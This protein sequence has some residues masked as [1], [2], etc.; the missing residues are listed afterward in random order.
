MNLKQ[1]RDKVASVAVAIEIAFMLCF[2]AFALVVV[3]S[4]AL[5]GELAACWFDT[6]MI[7]FLENIKGNY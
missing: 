7:S 6:A 5:V 4:P 3:L 1:I 2:I